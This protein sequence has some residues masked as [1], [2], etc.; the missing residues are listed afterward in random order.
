LPWNYG[1]LSQLA[2]FLFAV[3]FWECK[4]TILMRCD[5]FSRLK[6]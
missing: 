4:M 3:T 6:R 2:V 5:L 1:N